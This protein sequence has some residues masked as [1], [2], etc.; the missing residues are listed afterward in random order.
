MGKSIKI[1]KG[2]DIK[3]VG[4]AKEVIDAIGCSE[5]VA[6]K[7]SDFKNLSP[8]LLVAIGDEV[9][10]GQK[11]FFDKDNPEVG[12][13]SPVSGEVVE[14]VRAEKRRITHIKILS[15]A[16]PKSLEFKVPSLLSK[17]S[18]TEILLESGCWA[19]IR[20]RPFDIIP[21]P[22]SSPKA[23]FVSLFDSAPL[24]PSFNYILEKEEVSLNKGLEAL[25]HLC[26]GN[27]HVSKNNADS[28]NGLKLTSGGEEHQFSGPHPAGNVGIQIHHIDP[29][30]QGEQV[31]YVNA[32]DVKII[33][34]LFLTGKYN[35]TRKVALVGSGVVDPQ[36][37][38]VTTGQTLQSIIYKKILEDNQRVILGNILTGE[39]N[40]ETDYL[41]FYTNQITVI[42]E[43]NEPE[44]LGWLLPGL[45]KLSLSR[46]Y[47]SWLM[48]SKTYNLNTNTHGE[49]RPFVVTG[50]YEKVLP[51]NIMPNVLLK[52]ILSQDIERMEQ[53]GIYE[54]SE[55]DFALCEF[56]C[57]SKIDVQNIISEGLELIRKEG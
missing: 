31:W 53:L 23:I 16:V 38:E 24:A 33:G 8:K 44:F 17:E 28:F 54:V 21:N 56:V 55:E 26:G 14:I 51:M 52:S 6:L 32:Q 5:T 49:V 2:F 10:V 22:S 41:S 57:T 47:F 45:Q 35:P 12:I 20:Q 15:D 25:G 19:Y 40:N 29:I 4:S 46:S 48:P 39:T 7:P 37:Y 27:I 43:G 34:E 18:V 30:K 42:S 13:P 9:L 36:Y 1:S 3:I 11:V 50:Q